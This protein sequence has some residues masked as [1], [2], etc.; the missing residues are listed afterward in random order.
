V[1][2]P[3]SSAPSPTAPTACPAISTT[4]S[5]AVPVAARSESRAA[6]Q[7]MSDPVA[8]VYPHPKS[9]QAARADGVSAASARPRVPAAAV[10]VVM[11]HAVRGDRVLVQRAV[12]IATAGR[13]PLRQARPVVR[14]ARARGAGRP[15]TVPP[16]GGRHD[17]PE[18]L[19]NEGRIRP[20]SR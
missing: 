16:I 7:A 10:A 19:E 8:A 9:R 5:R 20:L 18:G 4:K 17:A 11:V 6:V 2:G 12:A 3:S 1:P 15:S 13:E 14:P